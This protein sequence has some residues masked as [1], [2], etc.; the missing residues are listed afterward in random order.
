MTVCAG[1]PTTLSSI[2][3]AYLKSDGLY[4]DAITLIPYYGSYL[5][6]GLTEDALSRAWGVY[7][8]A[9]H[10]SPEAANLQTSIRQRGEYEG[11]TVGFMD[12]ERGAQNYNDGYPGMG[13]WALLMGL[14]S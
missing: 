11:R 13:L 14:N 9:D 5:P 3:D 6:N 10:K 8:I 2:A 7:C 1:L 4:T 12:R